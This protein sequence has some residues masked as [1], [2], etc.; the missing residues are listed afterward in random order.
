M[1]LSTISK[2]FAAETG[3][4]VA[5]TF[6]LAVLPLLGMVGVAVDYSRIS[7]AR[8][9]KQSVADAAALAGA[10]A[11]LARQGQLASVA[12][13]AAVA[14]A[15]AV[16]NGGAPGAQ[17]TITAALSTRTV[18]VKV[19]QTEN[20][21]FGG[22][23]GKETS[24]VGAESAAVFDRKADCIT[25]L[26]AG[27]ERLL[28]NSNATI[29]ANCGV[30]VN[31]NSN[32]ALRL[33]DSAKI[34]A[35]SV[36]VVGGVQAPTGS[37]TPP[38][39]TGCAN[40]ADPLPSLPE[41][42]LATNAC[43]STTDV[44]ANAGQTRTLTPNRVYCNKIEANGGTID[45]PPGIYVIRNAALTVNSGGKV[46][47]TGVMIFLMGEQGVL[48]VNSDSTFHVSAPRPARIQASCCS[49]AATPSRLTR[50]LI[51]ST[52]ARA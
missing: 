50:P 39:R 16:V 51:R 12:E 10:Q 5:I 43:D 49:R 48:T 14:A 30:Q 18:N 9:T 31:S 29:K 23:V 38:A 27:P 20:I 22:F 15:T 37:I 11:M 44:V 4:A 7:L 45:F 35:T 3:G 1:S 6:A 13:E 28:L 40:V 52:A 24:S 33:T 26:G 17:K 8:T 46:T 32:P 34:E 36:C 25:V 41:P 47:G 19:T 2:R 21:I 42:P